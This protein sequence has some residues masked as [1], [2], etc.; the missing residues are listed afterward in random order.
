MRHIKQFVGSLVW[1]LCWRTRLN[2][3]RIVTDIGTKVWVWGYR[4]Y[5][6]QGGGR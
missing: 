1:Q 3:W 2:R 4:D 6:K 5:Y